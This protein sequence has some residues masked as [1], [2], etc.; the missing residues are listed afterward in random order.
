MIIAHRLASVRLCDRIVVM[1][2]GRITSGIVDAETQRL[3]R[4]WQPAQAAADAGPDADQVDLD[5]LL[6]AEGA[7]QLDLFDALQL[8]AV[9]QVCRT[10]ASLSEV[11]CG[12]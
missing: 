12:A 3:A 10:S 6:G 1:E 5:A 9:V 7:A 4:L 2:A 8:Q 11:R